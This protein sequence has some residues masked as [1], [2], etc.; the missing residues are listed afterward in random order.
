MTAQ[1][2][3]N[4]AIARLKAYKSNQ[5]LVELL[6]DEARRKQAAAEIAAVD[7]AL[8]TLTPPEF[9]II[10][11]SYIDNDRHAAAKLSLAMNYTDTHVRRLRRGVVRKVALAMFGA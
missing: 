11:R 7:H 5:R 6:D 4:K 1:E 9:E 8:A 2:Q 3:E 10:W